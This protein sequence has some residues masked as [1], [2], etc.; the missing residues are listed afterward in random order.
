MVVKRKIIYQRNGVSAWDN[1]PAYKYK[2]TGI[3]RTGKRFSICSKDWYYINGINVFQGSKWLVDEN[4]S[5]HL[6]CRIYN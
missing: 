2:A 3:D 6:I 5:K 1:N 4:G